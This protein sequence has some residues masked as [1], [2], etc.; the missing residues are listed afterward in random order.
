MGAD[1]HHVAWKDRLGLNRVWEQDILACSKLFRMDGYSDAVDRFR[2]N[3]INIKDGPQLRDIV[4]E[5]AKGELKS[6]KMERLS[7]W[8]EENRSDARVPEILSKTEAEINMKGHELLYNFILQTLEDN[9]FCFYQ[10]K[11][12]ED[13]IL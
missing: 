12:D 2:N 8:A 7:S 3:M 1:G 13:E 11:I 10:S 5:Y 9:G 6:W 4:S